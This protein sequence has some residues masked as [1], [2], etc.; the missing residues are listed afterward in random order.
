MIDYLPLKKITALH[1]EE[2]HE[3]ARRVIDSGWYL[4]GEETSRFEDEYA[5]YI[6]TQH[7]VGVANGL[8]EELT[9]ERKGQRW[10]LTKLSR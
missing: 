4:Q 5:A 2:I 9:F 8:E 3:A 1:A 6:G 10:M 7:C